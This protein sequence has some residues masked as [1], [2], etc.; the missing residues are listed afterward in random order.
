MNPKKAKPDYLISCGAIPQP[1]TLLLRVLKKFGLSVP[2]F[3]TWSACAEE[4]I[5]SG[6]S[7]SNNYYA[8]SH[9][10]S[11]YDEYPRAKRMREITLKYVPGT[12]KPY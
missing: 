6:G 2:V 11:W 7:A 5:E 10:S 12:E 1:I 9:M 3:G 8:I 4:V